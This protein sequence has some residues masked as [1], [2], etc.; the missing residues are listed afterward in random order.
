MKKGSLMI[1]T[2]AS[3]SCRS[4]IERDNCPRCEGTGKT[5]D[6]AAIRKATRREAQS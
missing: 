5:L 2:G 4:G 1:Y 3:C 6:F